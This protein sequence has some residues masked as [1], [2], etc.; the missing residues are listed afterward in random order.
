M[1]PNSS[2][3][4]SGRK[5]S[6]AFA[7]TDYSKSDVS[8]RYP[9]VSVAP[10]DSDRHA[11]QDE[12]YNSRR[13][14][15]KSGYADRTTDRVLSYDE[16]CRLRKNSKTFDKTSG[17]P[18]SVSFGAIAENISEKT[19]AIH[20]SFLR[21]TAQSTFHRREY[22]HSRIVAKENIEKPWRDVNSKQWEWGNILPLVGMATGLILAGYFIY[23]AVAAVVVHKY[24]PVL[25]DDFET[26]NTSVWSTEVQ[27]GGFG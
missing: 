26:F 20:E 17:G 8:K 21:K 18:K 3:N 4:M 6:V 19:S 12:T 2:P 7:A 27:L 23:A 16:N 10:S 1:S 15:E 9:S 13:S 22:F 11:S 5:A 25:V 14:S 24:C